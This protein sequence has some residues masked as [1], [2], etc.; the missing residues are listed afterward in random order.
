MKSVLTLLLVV[1]LAANAGAQANQAKAPVKP[2]TTKKAAPQSAAPNTANKAAPNAAAKTVTPP[3]ATKAPETKPAD[4]KAGN[5][6]AADT[7]AVPQQPGATKAP[8]TATKA[9]APAPAPAQVQTPVIMREVFAYQLDGRRDP[10]FSL[11]SSSDLRPTVAELRLTSVLY[12]ENGTNSIAMMRDLT[13][14]E[15]YRVTTGQTL[16]RMKVALIKRKVVIFSI[17]EF[18]MNRQDSLVLGDTTKV[19]RAK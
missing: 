13:T 7:K 9:P 4:T 16:G 12:D 5:T 3:A 14:N 8:A 18:G 6:K 10:F 15:Q 2:D 19:S 17:E 1:V 11:L